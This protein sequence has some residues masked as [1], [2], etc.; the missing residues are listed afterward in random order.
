MLDKRKQGRINRIKGAEWERVVRKDLEKNN[1]I[2]SKWQNNVEDEKL[3]PA[4]SNR[5]RMRTTGFPDFIFYKE[6]NI[7]LEYGNDIPISKKSVIS[8]PYAIMAV[9]CKLN[10]Y[11]TPEERNKCKWLLDNKIFNG[12]FIA[13]KGVKGIVYKRFE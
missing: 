10:G 4:K 5:F 3:I 1:W 12:I 6:V 8:M 7:G 13:S 9:E 11:L 2:V